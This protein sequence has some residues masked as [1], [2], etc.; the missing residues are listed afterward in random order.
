MAKSEERRHGGER[1]RASG[2]ANGKEQAGAGAGTWLPVILEPEA[3]AIPSLPAIARRFAIRYSTFDI[4]HS[5]AIRH[6]PATMAR[7]RTSGPTA[8]LA[9]AAVRAVF[10]VMQAFP[11]NWNLRTGR[12]LARLWMWAMPRHRDRAIAHLTA[13]LGDDY[14]PAQIRRIARGCLESIAMFAVE[15]VCLPRLL[16]RATW[17]RFVRLV[18]FHE[19]LR[20][21]VEGQGLILVTG[22]YGSFEVMGHILACLGLDVVAIMRPLDNVYLNRFLVESRGTHGLTLLDKKGATADAEKRLGAGA[23]L[24]F[25]GDQDAGRKGV[26]VD[27]F[28]QPASTY[29][30]IGLLA[31][32]TKSP[33]VVGYARRRGNVARYDAVVERVIHPDE[34]A[35]REDPLRWITQT[36]T[37][38]LESFIREAP[39]QY[40]WIHRRWK[41]KP[42]T[43][44]RARSEGGVAPPASEP[45]G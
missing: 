40:L 35:D 12:L 28:G 2:T 6:S 18:N 45:P 33:I 39:D 5:F 20:H 14:T 43:R 1:A 15:A 9:Y 41:S 7:M 38:A 27:F 19:T 26:F 34:W 16:N 32:A 44:R 24:S 17:P 10:A 13:S 25:V 11:V 29:K 42:R 37:A 8:W 30:S 21:I 3:W 36:Y 4:R 22:H 31:M 23:L